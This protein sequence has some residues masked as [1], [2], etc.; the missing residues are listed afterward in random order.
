[1]RKQAINKGKTLREAYEEAKAKGRLTSDRVWFHMGFERD[2]SCHVTPIY[3]FIKWEDVPE[4]WKNRSIEDEHTFIEDGEYCYG[5]D[6]K[7]WSGKS[8]YNV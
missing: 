6:N 4:E 7:P 8:M 1:M 5:H 2:D 3:K